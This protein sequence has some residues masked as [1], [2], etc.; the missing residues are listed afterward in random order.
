MNCFD[1]VLKFLGLVALIAGI[2]YAVTGMMLA[3]LFEQ[4][5]S[6]NKPAPYQPPTPYTP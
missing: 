5:H 2:S 6:H 1:C 4:P 3:P